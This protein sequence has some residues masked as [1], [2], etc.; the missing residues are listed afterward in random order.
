MEQIKKIGNK[1]KELR[2]DRGYSQDELSKIAECGR[3]AISSVENGNSI[4]TDNLC[5]IADSL[6][7]TI[8][9]IKNEEI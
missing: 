6:D 7:A 4:E 3:N 1:I 2:K 9:I 5:K 8:L